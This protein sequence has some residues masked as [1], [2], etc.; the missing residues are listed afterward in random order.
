MIHSISG[1]SIL[2]MLVPSSNRHWCPKCIE[3][4]KKWNI[5]W[6]KR[7]LFP[8]QFQR[9]VQIFPFTS[10]LLFQ[11]ASNSAEAGNVVLVL[12]PFWYASVASVKLLILCNQRTSSVFHI[13]QGLTL[14]NISEWVLSFL[15]CTFS[16]IFATVSC[17]GF[18]AQDACRHVFSTLRAA[19]AFALAEKAQRVWGVW[20]DVSN[21]AGVQK[22]RLYR[23]STV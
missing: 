12:W 2:T 7:V 19:E 3:K 21:V 15:V 4:V 11:G 14:G 17:F 18:S 22:K 6:N 23:N 9:A 10:E 1:Q 5:R 8:R 13:L 16:V 20:G